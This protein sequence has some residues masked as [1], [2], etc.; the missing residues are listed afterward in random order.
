MQN[1]ER[2][3]SMRRLLIVEA[4]SWYTI[5][6]VRRQ[7]TLFNVRDNLLKKGLWTRVVIHSLGIANVPV[8][9]V[10]RRKLRC[11]FTVRPH[12]GRYSG[13]S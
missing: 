3:H 8:P 6:P 4:T 2:R 13:A 10:P 11:I 5:K 1:E 9:E 7:L 12:T